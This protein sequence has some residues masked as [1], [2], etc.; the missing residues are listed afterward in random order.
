MFLGPTRPKRKKKSHQN[1]YIPA[2]LQAQ[3]TP[4]DP[5]KSPQSTILNQLLIVEKFM[6]ATGIEK[7]QRKVF[8]FP[9][10]KLPKALLYSG[11]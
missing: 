7:A 8:Q 1:S 6:E 10:G 5:S 11:W 2:S 4:N 9:D 3:A